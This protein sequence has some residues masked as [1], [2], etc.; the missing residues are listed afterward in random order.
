M[1]IKLL[2]PRASELPFNATLKVAEGCLNF[3]IADPG[4]IEKS[5]QPAQVCLIC[6]QVA[7]FAHR[8]RAHRIRVLAIPDQTM[9]SNKD[10]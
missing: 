7:A 8:H 9:I 10:R 3:G 5:C 2:E 1:T 4:F 6:H